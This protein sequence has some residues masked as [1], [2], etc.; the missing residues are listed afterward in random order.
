M[1]MMCERKESGL[2]KKRHQLFLLYYESLV[3][4]LSLYTYFYFLLFLLMS[5]KLYLIQNFLLPSLVGWKSSMCKNPVLKKKKKHKQSFWWSLSP[6]RI[7]LR[8]QKIRKSK[9]EKE[10]FIVCGKKKEENRRRK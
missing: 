4:L 8:F 1:E 6:D 9:S 10:K 2:T 7:T 5:I 3:L